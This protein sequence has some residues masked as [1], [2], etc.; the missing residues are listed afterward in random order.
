[1]ELPDSP[2]SSKDY[3]RVLRLA[4]TLSSDGYGPR[5]VAAELRRETR[6]LIAIARALSE[7]FGIPMKQAVEEVNRSEGSP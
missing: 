2:L 4:R 7:V 1:M 5:A 6:S 3:P